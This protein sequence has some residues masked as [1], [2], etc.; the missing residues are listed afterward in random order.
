MWSM[1]YVVEKQIRVY[2]GSHDNELIYFNQIDLVSVTLD[3]PL[4][5][6]LIS[7][8]MAD[9]YWKDYFSSV[10]WQNAAH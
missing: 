10:F 6:W 4:R 3:S 7:P 8:I 1:K 2:A 9:P 5:V